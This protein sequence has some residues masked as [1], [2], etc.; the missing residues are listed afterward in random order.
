MPDFSNITILYL[1]D[2]DVNLF[3]FKANFQS[4]FNVI[5]AN[6]PEQALV[7]LENNKDQIIVAISDMRMPIMSGIDFIR[8]ARET[9]DNIFYYILTGFDYNE[10][11]ESALKEEL[12]QKFFSKP[13]D[14]K[15]IEDEVIKAAKSL[16]RL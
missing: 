11:I 2:E 6:S 16:K 4:K 12:I 3:I 9:H 1:D 7:E 5:T 15:E 14:A 8:K 10:E 13:F